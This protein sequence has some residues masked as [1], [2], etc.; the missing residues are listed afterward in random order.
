MRK[1]CVSC[2]QEVVMG[3]FKELLCSNCGKKFYRCKRCINLGI[4][5]ECPHCGY[6]GP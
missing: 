4:G 3:E 5:W 2:N 6:K 1:I